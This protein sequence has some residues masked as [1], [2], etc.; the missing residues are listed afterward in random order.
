MP[1]IPIG[2]S[3]S[4]FLTSDIYL[5]TPKHRVYYFAN[6]MNAIVVILLDSPYNGHTLDHGVAS[7]S[8]VNMNLCAVSGG[9]RNRMEPGRNLRTCLQ[10]IL[11]FSPT[12]GDQLIVKLIM[13]IMANW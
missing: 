6:E 7:Q 13:S 10:T 4:K 5:F 9:P 3:L 12:F 1:L 2:L 8:M 11:I